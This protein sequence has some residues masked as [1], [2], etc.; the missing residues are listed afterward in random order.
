MTAAIKKVFKK[1]QHKLYRWH[2]LKNYRWELKKL[3]KLHDS[4]KIK[5]LPV[6]NHP[7]TPTEFEA[8]WK[9]LV[10]EYGLQEDDTIN[11]LWDSRHLWIAAY[12]KPSLREKPHWPSV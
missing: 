7:L 1:T 8:A 11:G 4:L 10:D 12:F 5:L 3:Y 6:I 9:E 2:M